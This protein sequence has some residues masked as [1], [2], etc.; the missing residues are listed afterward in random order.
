MA[1]PFAGTNAAPV[2]SFAA[3]KGTERLLN[4]GFRETLRNLS[5]QAHGTG[6]TNIHPC[7]P[8]PPELGV[9]F[10]CSEAHELEDRG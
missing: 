2:A 3:L 7:R 10:G 1:S 5:R 6:A 8:L 9:P 4:N